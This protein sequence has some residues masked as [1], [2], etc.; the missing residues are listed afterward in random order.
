[1]VLLAS[2]GHELAGHAISANMQSND[3]HTGNLFK[4]A[5]CSCFLKKKC[6][7]QHKSQ[8]VEHMCSWKQLAGSALLEGNH[9]QVASAPALAASMNR[10]TCAWPFFSVLAARIQ[11]RMYLLLFWEK[12]VEKLPQFP[13]GFC[14]VARVTETHWHTT[15][16][17]HAAQQEALPLAAI[18]ICKSVLVDHGTLEASSA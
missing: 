2:S 16:P 11:P 6:N 8:P 9:S 14:R 18:I 15:L 5:L 12:L 1:M 17:S 10:S 13:Q 4:D 7:N 3:E